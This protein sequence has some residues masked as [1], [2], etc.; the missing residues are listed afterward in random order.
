LLI[1]NETSK[2][3]LYEKSSGIA[4]ALF[5][6]RENPFLI[7][8]KKST[9]F[10]AKIHPLNTGSPYPS[11]DYGW[12]FHGD[13]DQPGKDSFYQTPFFRQLL[14]GLAFIL[15]VFSNPGG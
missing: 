1:T 8:S 3:S 15:E 10:D 9:V 6:L 7:R 4:K 13:T 2:I 14:E 5:P 11:A 12:V